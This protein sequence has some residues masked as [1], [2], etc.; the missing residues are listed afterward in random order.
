MLGQVHQQRHVAVRQR[1]DDVARLQP[2]QP[3]HRIGPWAQPVPAAGEVVQIG[4]RSARRCRDRPPA[5]PAR[6]GAG[7]P[8]W[9]RAARPGA[10][11]PS[12]AHRRPARHR[13][14]R[15]SRRAMPRARAEGGQLV[16]QAAAPVHH[17][18]EGVEQDGLHAL[19]GGGFPSAR[20]AFP[21]PGGWLARP[22][23]WPAE[24]W[25]SVGRRA[26]A[27]QPVEDAEHPAQEAGRQ[28]RQRVH[29]HRRVGERAAACV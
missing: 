14:A 13:P 21:R 19:H 7:R 15:S 11:G 23:F 12:R 1:R 5:A 2:G 4:R 6:R 3:R 17:G 20:F 25:P 10:P 18:A 29:R 22:Q 8:G 16:D 26:A 9:S 27:G 28:R 24:P